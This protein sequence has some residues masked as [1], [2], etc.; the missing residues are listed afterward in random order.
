MK[1]IIHSIHLSFVIGSALVLLLHSGAFAED[2]VRAKIG[3][4]ISGED[5]SRLAKSNDSLKPGTQFQIH[6]IPEKNCYVYL[7]N[8]DG[9]NAIW[10]NWGDDDKQISQGEEKIFPSA[11]SQY[12]QQGSESKET[13]TIICSPMKL[14]EMSQLFSNRKVTQ[15]YWNALENKFINKSHV[16]LEETL[17]KPFGIAG[18]VRANDNQNN[19]NFAIYS[20]KSMLV[21]KYNFHVKK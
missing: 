2:W 14:A 21:K 1:R 15:P 16:P 3:V 19:N 7:I 8:T 11:T 12:K 4:L 9:K 10:L 5:P 17:A 13:F 6:V 20:G 18:S